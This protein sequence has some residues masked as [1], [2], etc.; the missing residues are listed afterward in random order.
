MVQEGL[1]QGKSAL[2]TGCN[3]GIGRKV[4]E[5]LARNGAVVWACTRNP[6]TEFENF[7]GVLREECGARI[8]SLCFDM[9][10]AAGMADAFKQ[11]AVDPAGLDILVNNAGI[12]PPNTAFLMTRIEDMQKVFNVNLFAQLRM[13]QFAARLMLRRKSGSIVNIVSV[14]ALDGDPGQLEYVASKAALAGAT[15]K[16]AREFASFGIRVNA[17]APGVTR[18][19][20]IESMAAPLFEAA[21][22]RS[23]A[24]RVVEPDEIASVVL[25]LASDLSSALNGE[26]IR[27]DG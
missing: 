4:T 18:T 15:R 9:E 21:M 3:R 16:L 10:D 1:L 17:V 20:M 19:E 25:Y 13:I 14:A 22:A 26:I 6:N 2:V 7:V 24:G 8:E 11:V 23:A 5:V 27:A 12:V